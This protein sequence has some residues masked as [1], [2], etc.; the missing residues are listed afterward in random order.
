MY[1]NDVIF[2]TPVSNINETK[3]ITRHISAH[4]SDIEMKGGEVVGI[5]LESSG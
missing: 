4:T 1:K 3:K 5:L 2:S